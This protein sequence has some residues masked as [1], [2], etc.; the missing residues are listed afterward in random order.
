[1]YLLDP[2]EKLSM[3]T[4]YVQIKYTF[5][6]FLIRVKIPWAVILYFKTLFMVE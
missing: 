1:M 3:R 4:L 6:K 2:W 5:E